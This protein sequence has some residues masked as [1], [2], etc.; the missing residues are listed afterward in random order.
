MNGGVD[1]GAHAVTRQLQIV[2]RLHASQ[3]SAEVPK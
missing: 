1:L 2:A 3:N